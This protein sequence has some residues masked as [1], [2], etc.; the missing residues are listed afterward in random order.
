MTT[1]LYDTIAAVIA[2]QQADIHTCLI[3]RVARVG[4]DTIDVQPI[5]NREVDGKSVPLPLFPSVPPLF[6]QGGDSYSA[7]KI[8]VGDYCLLIINE[9]C[10]DRWYSGADMQSPP[11]Q[12][13]HNYSDA[14]AIVGVN[15]KG[16]A[17]PIP[18]V[19]TEM[20]DRYFEGDH[21]HLGDAEQTGD[22][23]INGDL[24][25][26]GNVT[27]NGNITCT[28]TIAAG[29]FTGLG[30]GAMTSTVTIETS[31]DMVASGVSLKSH[32]HGGVLPGGDDTGEPN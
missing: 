4:T 32:T 3:G 20:G 14:F 18:T 27:V 5:I 15:P 26:N 19:T 11:D 12:R 2:E 28:G 29:N 24:T 10:F 9:R 13:M 8:T 16:K 17:I 7:H 21:E 23:I 30:G 1:G 31:E 6:M 25:V 22:K